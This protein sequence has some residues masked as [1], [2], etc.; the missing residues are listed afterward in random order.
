MDDAALLEE[1]RRAA[2]AAYAPYSGFHVGAAALSRDGRVFA[3]ANVEN[4]SYGLTLCAERSA[5]AHAVGEGV[6]PGDVAAVAATAPPCGA[7]RQWLAEFRVDRVVYELD[8]RVH[9]RR[10]DELLPD[11]FRLS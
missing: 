5:L 1:A 3:G 9:V 8:G 10:P 2:R 7:C 11:T 4:A 6:V